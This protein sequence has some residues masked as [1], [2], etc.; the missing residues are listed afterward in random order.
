MA[1]TFD[2]SPYAL[3]EQV[4]QL[5]REASHWKEHAAHLEENLAHERKLHAVDCLEAGLRGPH[6][7]IGAHYVVVLSSTD[8]IAVFKQASFKAAH[9]LAARTLKGASGSLADAV[10]VM[11]LR[12]VATVEK[13]APRG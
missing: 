2:L 4:E 5:K 1:S 12:Q 11:V 9:R 3:A 10:R 8:G 13:G 6:F 7:G